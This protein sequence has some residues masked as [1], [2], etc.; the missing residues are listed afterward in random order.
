MKE[1]KAFAEG[2][3][4]DVTGLLREI[5]E[6]TGALNRTMDDLARE[7]LEGA[8]ERGIVRAKISGTGRLLGLTIDSRGL[9]DLDHVQLAAAVMEAVGAARAAMGDRLTELMSDLVGPEWSAQPGEDP[10]ASHIQRVLREG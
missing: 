8:D 2:R 5:N 1:I 4:G 3:E 7:R 9:N 10:L 6:W